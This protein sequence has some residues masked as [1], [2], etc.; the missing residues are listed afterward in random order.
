MAQDIEFDDDAFAADLELAERTKRYKAAEDEFDDAAFADASAPQWS[1]KGR[2][3][4][5][6][7]PR[8]PKTFLADAPRADILK[9][10]PKAKPEDRLAGARELYP[11]SMVEGIND[12]SVVVRRPSGEVY[13]F[14]APDLGNTLV[15]HARDLIPGLEAE[16]DS[17]TIQRALNEAD[18]AAIPELVI[19]GG[20]AAATAALTGPAI[21]ARGILGLRAIIPHAVTQFFGAKG[22][23]AVRAGV[24]TATAGGDSRT[25]EEL[26]E[27]ANTEGANAALM[28]AG[29]GLAARP[30]GR[31]ADSIKGRLGIKSAASRDITRQLG[32]GAEPS[33]PLKQSIDDIDALGVPAD[34]RPL[35]IIERA[36]P[37]AGPR[38]KEIVSDPKVANKAAF[39]ER[40]GQD[41]VREAGEQ[42][43][44][45]AKAGQRYDVEYS[46]KARNLA[47]KE[48]RQSD[49][50]LD[51]ELEAAKPRQIRQ[52]IEA[53]IPQNDPRLLKLNESWEGLDAARR[54][55][56]QGADAPEIAGPK[57]TMRA[58]KESGRRVKPDAPVGDHDGLTVRALKLVKKAVK[59]APSAVMGNKRLGRKLI[60]D[61]EIQAQVVEMLQNGIPEAEISNWLVSGAGLAGQELDKEP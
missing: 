26:N 8:P 12:G 27:Q 50:V 23:E 19:K 15:R 31:A 41:A 25:Y 60:N 49:P 34:K 43:V 7:T 52:V 58:V 28:T 30:L 45:D 32:G 55:A 9:L 13:N 54:T 53:K 24:N 39:D 18:G 48:I 44:R 42:A 20:S 6:A 57:A 21:A 16:D 46:R 4:Q 51:A 47:I 37:E 3:K 56:K 61:P 17:P 33:P 2:Q 5:G 35:S 14:E 59:A 36:N 22:A 38:L 29:L 10:G 1:M 11:D 40:V